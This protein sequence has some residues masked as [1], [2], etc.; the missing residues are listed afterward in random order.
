MAYGGSQ[1]RGSNWS[2]SHLLMPQSHQ[3]QI[4][5]TSATYTTA[6]HNAGFLTL[7]SLARDRTH[8]LT[9]PGWIHFYCARMGTPASY[10]IVNLYFISFF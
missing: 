5:A 3:L 9:V 6:H 2:Y 4:Q 1:L 10:K 8:N 7:L